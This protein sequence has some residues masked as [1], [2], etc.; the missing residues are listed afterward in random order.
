MSNPSNPSEQSPVVTF[1]CVN[2]TCVKYNRQ[3]TADQMG[4]KK[5]GE[6][7]NKCKQHFDLQS[8]I[9]ST[10]E[11]RERDYSAYEH[12][13]ERRLMKKEYR[14][15]NS[16]K[17]CEYSRTYRAKML[18]NEQTAKEYRQKAAESLRKYRA[19]QKEKEHNNE[20]SGD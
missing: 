3:F 14:Q 12:T 16:D 6:M 10:R 2:K 9:E 17:C 11:P 19:S 4:Y 18:S 8:K 7:S 5:N 20:T 13:L 1:T 15:E